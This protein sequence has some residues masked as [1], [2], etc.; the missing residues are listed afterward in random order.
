LKV[1]TAGPQE[2]PECSR[3]Y[4]IDAG[5]KKANPVPNN[6][7]TKI[8][9]GRLFE[10][11]SITIATIITTMS[12]KIILTNLLGMASRSAIGIVLFPQ[13]VFV[14]AIPPLAWVSTAR[15]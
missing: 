1:A 6:N 15:L 5:M 7:P 4:T 11:E 13:T 12:V 9:V 10:K 8:N 2:E 3:A 14:S